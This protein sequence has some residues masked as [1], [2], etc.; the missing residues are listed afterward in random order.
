MLD[1]LLFFTIIHVANLYYVLFSVLLACHT[2]SAA[3]VKFIPTNVGLN[4]SVYISIPEP[5]R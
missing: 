4:V 3:C 1:D 5:R 2:Y